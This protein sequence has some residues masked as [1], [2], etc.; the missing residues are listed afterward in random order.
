MANKIAILLTETERNTEVREM[1][2]NH[3]CKK[4]W[5]K[6]LYTIN[7]PHRY[8]KT[9]EWEDTNKLCDCVVRKIKKEMGKQKEETDG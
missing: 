2:S 8:G 7:I 5:G 1:Y 3:R 4:C 9:V 6:G